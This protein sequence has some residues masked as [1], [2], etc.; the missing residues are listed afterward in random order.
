MSKLR[1][2]A[3]RRQL[4][5]PA[6]ILGHHEMPRRPHHMRPQDGA[7]VEC[8]FDL[9]FGRIPDTKP[10]RPCGGGIVLRLDCTQMRDRIGRASKRRAAQTTVIEAQSENVGLDHR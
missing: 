4:D 2:H 6:D 10:D 3:R 9:G 1:F 5:H 8:S 7:F